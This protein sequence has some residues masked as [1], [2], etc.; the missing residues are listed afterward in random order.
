MTNAVS[1]T[2]AAAI[3]TAGFGRPG[4]AKCLVSAAFRRQPLAILTEGGRVMPS[5]DNS[6]LRW[7]GRSMRLLIMTAAAAALS[8][9]AFAQQ[10][11]PQQQQQQQQ[12]RPAQPQPQQ[13]QQQ[14]QQQ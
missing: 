2:G 12:Q 5:A 6:L 7:R 1:M 11:R 4:S 9:P 8:F 10:G 13:Q 3:R 14:Q